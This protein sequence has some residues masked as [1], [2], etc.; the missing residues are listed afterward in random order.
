M[1]SMWTEENVDEKLLQDLKDKGKIFNFLDKDTSKWD[2][3]ALQ[4]DG[5]CNYIFTIT[6]GTSTLLIKW[7]IVYFHLT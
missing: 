1:T 4:N 7:V 5:K 2:M 6:D 3:K